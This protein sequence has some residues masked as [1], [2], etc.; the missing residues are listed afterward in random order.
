MN[1]ILVYKA[2]KEAGLAHAI[3]SQASVAYY[4]P[5]KIDL[6]PK[7][8]LAKSL[9]AV[10][11]RAIAVNENQPDLFYLKDILVT[12]GWNLNDDVFDLAETWAARHS[13]EDKQFNLHHNRKVEDGKIVY[14]NDIVGHMTAQYVINQEGETLADDLSVDELPDKFHIVSTSVMYRYWPDP[15]Y[16]KMMTNIIAEIESQTDEKPKWFVS[17]EALF[18]GFD[19]ALINHKGEH[20]VIARTDSSAFLTKHLRA[21]GGKGTYKDYKVGRLLRNIVFS[22]KGLVENPANPESVIFNNTSAFRASANKINPEDLTDTGYG[23]SSKVFLTE[24][25]SMN[26]TELLKK[27]LADATAALATEKAAR[28][29]LEK[30][31]AEDAQ[32]A[33]Q[34]KID[35]ANK[36]AEAANA[37]AVEVEAALSAKT[38]EVAEANKKLEEVNK[39]LADATA[40]L[41]KIEDEKRLI[42]RK[43]ELVSKLGLDEETA[44]GLLEVLANLNDEA[45]AKYVEKAPKKVDAA[46]DEEKKK[47]DEKKKKEDEEAYA[48]TEAAKAEAA[49][50]ALETATANKTEAGSANDNPNAQVEETRKKIAESY[51]ATR[52]GKKKTDESAKN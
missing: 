12:T 2:E 27:Q 10:K 52:A 45:F 39:K 32:K 20:T 47:A 49:K 6:N 38:N 35:E 14:V 3:Q 48:K 33:A 23:L 40:A 46:K 41:A 16:M 26:E 50:K 30:K 21:Y 13:A 22:G 34:A 31:A 18:G 36:V 37:K 1:Q 43:S 24:N 17:M 11:Q 28:A 7:A 8:E 25:S 5:V 44:A 15:D 42:A 4:S 19:Y 51:K 29:D 9:A